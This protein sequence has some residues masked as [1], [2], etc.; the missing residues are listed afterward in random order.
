VGRRRGVLAPERRPDEGRQPRREHEGRGQDH[1]RERGRPEDT[2]PFR[3][4]ELWQDADHIVAPTGGD[5]SQDQH[6]HTGAQPCAARDGEDQREADERGKPGAPPVGHAEQRWHGQQHQGE[7]EICAEFVRRG[8][9]TKGARL[10]HRRG[11]VHR[12]D[13]SVGLVVGHEIADAADVHLEDG[14]E[15]SRGGPEH[16]RKRGPS[17]YDPWQ[18]PGAGKNPDREH[19]R[20]RLVERP[21]GVDGSQQVWRHD[22]RDGASGEDGDPHQFYAREQMRLAFQPIRRGRD[23][24]PASQRIVPRCQQGGIRAGGSERARYNIEKNAVEWE[25]ADEDSQ[26]DPRPPE[27]GD[28]QTEQSEDQDSIHEDRHC[29]AIILVVRRT[30]NVPDRLG[31]CF[32][33]TL[34]RTGLVGWHLAAP[35]TSRA[36]GT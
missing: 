18:A 29:P 12:G 5:G 28:E 23:H 16:D 1:E 17:P 11:K 27:C 33:A 30:P 9:R 21:E 24:E 22:Q 8:E 14:V 35:G 19:Q 31:P 3:G 20:Y 4:A 34:P 13:P 10:T 7:H 36:R 15:R 6:G 32:P 25:Q 2:P 26:R